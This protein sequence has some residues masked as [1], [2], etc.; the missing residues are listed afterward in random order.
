MTSNEL[1]RYYRSKVVL[2][3]I[4]KL[5]GMDT[6]Q[7]HEWMKRNV[8]KKSTTQFTDDEFE[9]KMAETRT[10]FSKEGVWIPKP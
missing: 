4:A 6:D 1:M 10:M 8:F 5:K 7:A 3:K 9:E 2:G